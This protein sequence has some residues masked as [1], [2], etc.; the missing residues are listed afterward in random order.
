[1]NFN[2]PPIIL[3]DVAV[4]V[5]VLGAEVLIEKCL[6]KCDDFFTSIGLYSSPGLASPLFEM[7]SV[8]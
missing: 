1:M 2:F 3:Y 8:P 5:T 4:N 6:G 7:T